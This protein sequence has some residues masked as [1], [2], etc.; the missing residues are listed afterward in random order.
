MGYWVASVAL[1]A[2]GLAGSMT[3]GRSFFIVGLAMLVLG[4]LRRR[5]LLFWPPMAA[6]LSYD[7]IFWA[8]S[9]LYCSATSLPGASPGSATCSSLLGIGWPAT[10]GGLADAASVFGETDAVALLAAAATFAF[11]LAVLLWRRR[12][13]PSAME[14]R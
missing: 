4:P 8:I 5:P 3:I 1:I 11:V 10:A 2:S 12:T 13:A 7:V 9:P 14:G 6:V